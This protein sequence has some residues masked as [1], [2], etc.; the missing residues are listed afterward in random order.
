MQIHLVLP[1]R[2]WATQAGS[3]R[4]WAGQPPGPG[5]GA[6]GGAW[7]RVRRCVG[8]GRRGRACS[9]RGQ[10]AEGGPTAG[11][12]RLSG[13]L[14]GPDERMK[15]SGAGTAH[16]S[17]AWAPSCGKE[18]EAGVLGEDGMGTAGWQPGKRAVP[19]SGAPGM[20][21][22]RLVLLYS[23]HKAGAQY[24]SGVRGGRSQAATEN[25]LSGGR[26]NRVVNFFL[27]GNH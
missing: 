9:R 20:H 1:P 26:L 3:F 16:P 5:R 25:F 14:P 18:G 6:V 7:S 2:R 19:A 23:L 17:L 13:A 15:P 24:L 12:F 4:R 8:R 10:L 21:F 22:A 11:G 27:G